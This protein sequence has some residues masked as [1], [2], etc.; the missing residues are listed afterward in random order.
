[1]TSLHASHRLRNRFGLAVAIAG[2]VCAGAGIAA[3]IGF[4]YL[5]NVYVLPNSDTFIALPIIYA[6]EALALVL[7]ALALPL[8]RYGSLRFNL[9]AGTAVGTSLF[10]ALVIAVLLFLSFALADG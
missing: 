2:M 6:L 9:I 8:L 3:L 5:A 7:G 10:V 4:L 1:M